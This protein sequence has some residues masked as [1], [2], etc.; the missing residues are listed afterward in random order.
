MTTTAHD[1]RQR[2]RIPSRS[3]L[4]DRFLAAWKRAEHELLASWRKAHKGAR[5]P[6]AATLILWAEREHHAT[7]DVADFLHNCREARNA[8][9]H[10]S[11][12]GYDGP[13]THPPAQ[14]VQRLER[15]AAALACPATIASFASRAVTC[16]SGTSLADALR[17]MGENDFSQLPYQHPQHGWV[18]VTREQVS[19]WLE[20]EADEEGAVLSELAS[21]VS[22]LADHPTVGPVLVRQVASTATV[23]D[24]LHELEGA[25]RT[26]DALPGGY[27]TVLA[28]GRSLADELWILTADD[29][30]RMYGLLGR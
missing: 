28:R 9:A 4:A 13:V 18:V 1:V 29:L 2:E 3:S 12:G 11:F 7:A 25:L 26:S 21:P 19:R 30:P 14:V 24:A 22:A 5:D 10:V 27:P 6:D 16:S 17:V 8:Y 20:A 15:I 23:I